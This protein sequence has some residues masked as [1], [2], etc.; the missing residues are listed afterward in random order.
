MRYLPD[1]LMSLREQTFR[2]FSILVIDNASTDGV[3]EFLREH[4]PDVNVI[5]NANNSGFAGAHNQG[6]KYALHGWRNEGVENR[7]VLVTNPDIILTPDCMARIV[8]EADLAGER[9]GSLGAKLL[10]VT[11]EGEEP[12]TE[13]T[14]T[15][16][17]DSTGLLVRRGRRI[18]DR[19]AGELDRGQYDDVRDVFGVSGALAL[20]RASALAAVHMGDE[21]FDAAFF[22]YKEDADMAWRLR[23]AGY[24]ARFV[25]DA[26]AYHFRRAG[27]TDKSG[28]LEW[29]KNYRQ[30]SPLISFYSYRNH[31]ALLF[32]NE[33]VIHFL[34][35]AVW[36]VLY[37][38]GKFFS[39][40][41][42]EPRTLAGGVSF[43][44]M[45]P[46]LCA[47]RR[48]IMAKRRISAREMRKWLR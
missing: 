23:L 18:T 20:L 31:C 13:T 9:C 40:L 3:I 36:I 39:L 8:E 7:Y 15:S 1:L 21:Y 33:Q 34:R 35:D 6:I 32:K 10:R 27:G 48:A 26:V 41:F 5:R 17:I 12:L 2:D 14:R 24:E 11:R 30:K 22:A 47:K 44:K 42:L 29:L 45:V 37:E 28:P 25:P 16:I 38:V 46:E 19:G 4:Y 43:L